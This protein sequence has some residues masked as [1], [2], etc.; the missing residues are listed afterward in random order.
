[1]GPWTPQAAPQ[2]R[3]FPAATPASTPGAFGFTVQGFGAHTRTIQ[4]S[5]GFK[6][7]VMCC[8][9]GEQTP[10]A[11]S[12]LLRSVILKEGYTQNTKPYS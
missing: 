10:L 5:L 12:V 2:I 7:H 9:N 11:G 3:R 4:A 1:M 6:G 8:H